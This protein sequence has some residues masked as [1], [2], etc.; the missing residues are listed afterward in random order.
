MTIDEL[1]KFRTNLKMYQKKN[2]LSLKEFAE[3]LDVPL[4]TAHGWINGVPPK[5]IKTIKE[6]SQAL[7]M[8]FDELCFGDKELAHETDLVISIGPESFRLIF[9]KIDKN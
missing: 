6:I 9:K 8:T 4:S 1:M 3:K 5:S 7:N 2:N